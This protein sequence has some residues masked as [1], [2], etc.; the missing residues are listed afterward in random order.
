M[1]PNERLPGGDKLFPALSGVSSRFG[2]KPLKQCLRKTVLLPPQFRM[3][4]HCHYIT[5]APS[6]FKSFNQTI[7]SPGGG[8]KIAAYSFYCL[9]MMT[10]DE[11]VL[12]VL[13]RG[14]IA[15]AQ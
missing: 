12:S 3:P 11:R 13:K 9:M 1:G 7:T 8:L 6:V 5:V 2:D 15:F 4:L 14:E 10:V